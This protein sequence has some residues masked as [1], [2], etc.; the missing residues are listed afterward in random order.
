MVVLTEKDAAEP[1]E[2]QPAQAY[3][4]EVLSAGTSVFARLLPCSWPLRVVRGVAS[5]V[6]QRGSAIATGT[7]GLGA[8]GP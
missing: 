5:A 4:V 8:P 3:Q 6:D 2:K 1:S 7:N